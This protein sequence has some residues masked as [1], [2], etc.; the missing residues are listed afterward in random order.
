MPAKSNRNRARYLPAT[1]LAASLFFER[2]GEVLGKWTTQDIVTVN[3][4]IEAYQCKMIAES[5]GNHLN[6]PDPTM[7]V[8]S[9]KRLFGAACRVISDLIESENLSAVFDGVEKQYTKNFWELLIAANLWGNISNNSFETLLDVF[10]DQ[11]PNLL[12][13]QQVVDRHGPSLAGAMRTNARISAETIIGALAVTGNESRRLYLPHS[14]SNADIDRIMLSYLDGTYP[15]IRLNYAN[16]LAEWPSSAN[17]KYRPSP[18]VRVTAQ[19][20]TK[21]LEKEMFPDPNASVRF[22]SEVQFSPEQEACKRVSYE[23]GILTHAFGLKW[24]QKYADPATILNNFLYVFDLV[25]EDGMLNY[26]SHK[27]TGSTLLKAIGLHAID[28]YPMTP[29]AQIVNAAALQKVVGYRRL[30][31]KGETRL[32]DAIEWFFND[33]IKDEFEIEGFSI[34]LPTEETSWLDK[35]KAIGPEIERVLKAFMLYAKNRSIDTGYFPYI[36]IRDFGEVLSLFEKKYL[37]EGEK[38][39]PPANLLL[40]DQSPLAYS[41]THPEEDGGFCR[42]VMRFQLTENDFYEVYHP[43]I[44]Y[45][46]N[47]GFVKTGNDGVLQLTSRACLI[48]LVWNRGAV[49]QSDLAGLSNLIEKM[50]SENILA[51][52]SSLFSPDE[53]DYLCYLLNNAKFS[54]AL[55]L[56]NK[57][58]HGSGSIFDSTEKKMESDYCLMLTALI[59]ITLKINEELSRSTGRGGINACD[60]IDWPLVEG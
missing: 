8:E 36:I 48:M 13:C 3:D 51:Y 25:G 58:D 53:A 59:G 37:V 1:D 44:E 21:S 47:N 5:Y 2:A 15:D 50:V 34:S 38:F 42:L 24:L 57:Y 55:A 26:A 10:P 6:G 40:S 22:G 11:I 32:E 52:S 39:E 45:L 27:R 49:K 41:P 29:E 18:A 12:R 31:L 16:V 60:L 28:E 9:A 17:E 30:L 46:I 35:C 43:Q 7:L 33:Y 19:R 20:R 23:N 56:R 54:N 14:L 4:A